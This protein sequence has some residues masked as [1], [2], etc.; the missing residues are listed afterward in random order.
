MEQV[1]DCTFEQMPH[2]FGGLLKLGVVAVLLSG[3]LGV[4]GVVSVGLALGL[5]LRGRPTAADGPAMRWPYLLLLGVGVALIVPGA[6]LAC[7]F[8]VF[9]LR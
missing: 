1:L 4:A 9:V 3:I 2:I 8:I 5:G 7:S 6:W